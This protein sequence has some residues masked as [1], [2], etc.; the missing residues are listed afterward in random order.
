MEVLLV[1]LDPGFGSMLIQA[2]IAAIAVGGAYLLLFKKK[3]IG[4]F[5]KGAPQSTEAKEEE[6][7]AGK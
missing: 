6:G 5:K 3:I 4:L 7:K 1:Y 2:L